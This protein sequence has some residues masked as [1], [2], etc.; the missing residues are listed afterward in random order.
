MFNTRYINL[1]NCLDV[2]FDYTIHPNHR[3]HI[4]ASPFCDKLNMM[5]KILPHIKDRYIIY[6]NCVVQN[7]MNVIF[8]YADVIFDIRDKDDKLILPFDKFQPLLLNRAGDYILH[9][10]PALRQAHS[11]KA[12]ISSI[13]FE[14]YNYYFDELR[15]D[16]NLE[17]IH[18]ICEQY[19]TIGKIKI[20]PIYDPQIIKLEKRIAQL[21][22]QLESLFE[23]GG[24]VEK[25]CQLSFERTSQIYNEQ[26]NQVEDENGG[27][28]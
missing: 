12:G 21:E 28:E 4:L 22:Q 26:N 27:L 15:L 24:I 14:P 23:P 19:E 10:L 20:D 11:L 2:V 3:Q 5:Y 18:D 8:G 17:Q 25:V 16:Y 9:K 6:T 7:D 1:E 13:K